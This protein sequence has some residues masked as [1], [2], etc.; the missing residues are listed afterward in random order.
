[1]RLS[2]FFRAHP[3]LDKYF[4]LGVLVIILVNP[5]FS[6]NQSQ[7]FFCGC[8]KSSFDKL[9]FTSTGFLS[10]SLR[11]TQGR[12]NGQYKRDELSLRFETKSWGLIQ[13]ARA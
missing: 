7:E 13:S 9:A 5:D 1:M 11:F 3:L 8:W 10:A 12:Q 4:Y 6:E 2:L